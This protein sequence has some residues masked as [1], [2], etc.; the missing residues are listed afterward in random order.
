MTNE[1]K[2]KRNGGGGARKKLNA[3]RY[4]GQDVGQRVDNLT[5]DLGL[6]TRDSICMFMSL[7]SSKVNSA[8]PIVLLTLKA[9]KGWN[10]VPEIRL[11]A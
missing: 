1:K 4:M 8:T 3:Y 7:K 11:E 10:L 5:S 9:F 2:I 6:F